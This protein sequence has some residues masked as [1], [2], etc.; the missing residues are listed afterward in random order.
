L[1][2]NDLF[3]ATALEHAAS[4]D[5]KEMIGWLLA[6]GANINTP[7]Y[8]PLRVAIKAGNRDLAE[9][10]IEKGAD[11]NA[12][13][14]HFHSMLHEA[15]RSHHNDMVELLIAHGADLN[16]KSKFGETPLDEAISSEQTDMVLVLRSHGAKADILPP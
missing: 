2:T 12:Q 6:H 14:N 13:P 10:L 15:V 5:D 9:F 4:V 1:Y 16:P 3:E 11:V 8:E 7:V